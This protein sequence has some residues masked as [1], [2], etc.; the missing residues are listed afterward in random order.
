MD[1]SVLSDGS[2][3]GRLLVGLA[4]ELERKSLAEVSVV[5]IVAAAHVSK[6]TFYEH[7]P[8]RDQCFLALYKLLGE[9]IIEVTGAAAS[10]A[11]EDVPFS[12]RV[13]SAFQAY[14]SELLQH[15][16]LSM[17]LYMGILGAG[18]Q[19]LMLRQRVN[20][21]FANV[22]LCALQK[23]KNWLAPN[24]TTDRYAML[25]AIAGANELIL[26]AMQQGS[27]EALANVAPAIE[28]LVSGAVKQAASKLSSKKSLS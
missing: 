4:T 16:K 28:A 6:R 11:G 19:G 3:R 20:E 17:A 21:Q 13:R 24:A 9:R 26:Y 23:K 15:P 5:N 2:S 12:S 27:P 22:I 1:L 18:E 10:G 8:D 25:G 7:F 14:M